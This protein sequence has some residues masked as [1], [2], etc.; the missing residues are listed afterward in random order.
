MNRVERIASLIASGAFTDADRPM[1]EAASDSRLEQFAQQ[2]A[3]AETPAPQPSPAPAATVVPATV[4]AYINA[5]PPEM[6]EALRESVRVAS[7]RKETH[8]AQIIGTG[9]SPYNETELRTM[10]ATQLEKLAQ[11]AAPAAPAAQAAQSVPD[12]SLRSAAFSAMS[13][14]TA[15]AEVIPPP[16]DIYAD[17]RTASSIKQ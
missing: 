12:Y 3:A 16:K 11:L 9:R 2:R 13:T 4:D 15:G 17:I 8:I 6:Q 10:S 5:A 1:L 14:A 7:A